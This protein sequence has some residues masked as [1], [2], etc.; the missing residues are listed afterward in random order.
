MEAWIDYVIRTLEVVTEIPWE[1][2]PGFKEFARLIICEIYT[3]EI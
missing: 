3:Q 1:E 2:V